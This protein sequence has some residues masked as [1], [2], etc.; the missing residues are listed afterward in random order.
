[1][2]EPRDIT[3]RLERERPVPRPTFVGA[4]RRHLSAAPALWRELPGRL[5]LHVAAYSGGGLL[6]LLLA[7]LGVAGVG[8]FAA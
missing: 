5:R 8:P 7:A 2:N 4:V 1:M 6:L 3:E